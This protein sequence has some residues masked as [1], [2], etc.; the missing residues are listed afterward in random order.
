MGKMTTVNGDQRDA[1]QTRASLVAGLQAGEEGRWQEFYQLYGPLIRRFALKAGLSEIE[2]DEVVQETAIA[3]ARHVPEY[4]S[5]PKVCRFKTWLLNQ[6]A[7]RVKDQLKKRHRQAVW[8]ERGGEAGKASAA[9]EDTTRTATV[10]RMPSPHGDELGRLW[11]AEWQESLLAAALQKAKAQFS[12]GEKKPAELQARRPSPKRVLSLAS[13]GFSL[14]RLRA[15]REHREIP[16]SKTP[17]ARKIILPWKVPS[18]SG[19]KTINGIRAPL[20]AVKLTT[21]A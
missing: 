16:T 5:D 7:W 18:F 1:I 17:S 14:F 3:V 19:F 21:R 20:T 10:E 9:S 13:K 8:I 15:A 11:E 4:R 12:M 2:A 6:T